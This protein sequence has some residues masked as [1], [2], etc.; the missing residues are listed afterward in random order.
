MR[1][2]VLGCDGGIGKGLRTT[3]FLVDD[4]VLIDAGSG[5]GELAEAALHRIEHVFLTHA[6]LDHIA[7]LPLLIDSTMERR[8]RPVVVHATE[9]TLR[10]LREHVF[11]WKIW[12]DFTRIPSAEKP[13]LRYVAVDLGGT[14]ELGKRRFT[15]L[16]A[17]HT[18]PTVGYRLD[19]GQASLVFT[20]DTARCDAF[21]DVVN[22]I[23]KLKYLIIETA[24]G[25]ADY[26]RAEASGH[27]C[28]KSLADSLEKLER[29][30]EVV[31]THMKPGH[32]E[33]IMDEI[34][35]RPWASPPRQ[36]TCGQ[37]LEF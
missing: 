21:W 6:H 18:V 26:S 20:G 11:N 28:P 34:S 24:F 8:A 7:F 29:P 2:E 22:R 3:A 35:A 1:L 19:S 14:A 9:E 32:H 17:Q 37:V 23:E 30:T 36:L 10:A 25:D 13:A 12:P 4:D 27:L 33:T 5:V 15:P 31:I 16:P